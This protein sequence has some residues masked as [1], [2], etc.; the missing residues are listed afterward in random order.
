MDPIAYGAY[1]ELAD[2]YAELV[3]TKP[4]NA[5][6]DRPAVLSLLPELNELSVLDAGCGTGVY[7]KLFVQM[8]AKVA[9]IE[10][11]PKMLSYAPKNLGASV[12]LHLGDLRK[13][14]DYLKEESEILSNVV[15]D[16]VWK[17]CILRMQ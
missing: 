10:V 7:S 4:H 3:E 11:S 17:S 2:S 5:F 6:Y 1:E 14:L 8:G 13:P 16:G 9:G 12:E 15:D